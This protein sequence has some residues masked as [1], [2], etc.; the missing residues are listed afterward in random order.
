VQF[1]AST[2]HELRT[3]LGAIMGFSSFLLQEKPGPLNQ[4]QREQMG[5]VRD[6]ARHLQDLTNDITDL[7]RLDDGRVAPAIDDFPLDALLE[8]AAA[9]VRKPAPASGPPNANSCSGPTA[10]STRPPR[11]APTAPVWA[12]SSPVA[13]SR[14]CWP[15]GSG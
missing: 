14:G 1:V 2:S 6:A 7:A 12:C 3:P 10:A 15:A 13:W 8:E 11:S 9:N 4:D 5:H